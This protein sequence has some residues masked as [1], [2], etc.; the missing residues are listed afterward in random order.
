MINKIDHTDIFP[1]RFKERLSERNIRV[2]TE[3]QKLTVPRISAGENVL[4]RSAT[5]TGKTFAYLLPIFEKLLTCENPQIPYLLVIAPTLELCSQIKSEA[6]FLLKDYANIK[7]TLIIGSANISRQIDS[8]KKEK[9]AV[10]IGNPARL[11]QLVKMGKLKLYSITA[12]VLDEGDRL[13]SE[14]L[15]DDTLELVKRVNTNR[16]S[17][18]CSATIS[19]KSKEKLFPLIG[20]DVAVLETS[21]QEILRDQITHWA[22]FS[23]GRRK[24]A[25]LSS[26]LNASRA[27]KALVFTNNSSQ[28]GNITT[29]LQYHAVSATGIYSGMNK[30]DRK[31]AF[32]DFKS[33]KARVLV[34]SDLAAR[35]LDIPAIS[36]VIELDVPSDSEVYIHR[37][38]RTGRAGRKGIM[39]TIGDEDELRRFSLLEKKLGITVYPKI[40]YKGRIC[41]PEQ[42]EEQ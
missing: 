27:K 22:F 15:F 40:L 16:Q 33:G 9:P 5:G 42:E 41:T 26:F 28:V 37:A 32:D 36:H 29:K 24:I 23:E 11:L 38:G 6:D 3:I 31:Q 4:F 7:T 2:P 34:S 18:T 25:T 12:L 20:K 10:I 35:G 21:A 14:E 13:C 17:I 19:E 1:E 39:V 30:K 8:L